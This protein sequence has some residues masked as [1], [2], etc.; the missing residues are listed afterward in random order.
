MR[1]LLLNSMVE[2]I[3]FRNILR[4]YGTLDNHFPSHGSSVNHLNQVYEIL[5]G[6]EAANKLGVIRRAEENK[7]QLIN[8]IIIDNCLHRHV[9]IWDPG[10][11]AR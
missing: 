3:I 7:K 8:D 11:P 10:S 9:H 4:V 1:A 6:S 5:L 2:E